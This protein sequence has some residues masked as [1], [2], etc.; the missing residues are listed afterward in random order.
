MRAYAAN[1]DFDWY[2]H[3]SRL[4]ALDEVNFWMPRPWG[5]E[6][7]VLSRGEP[8][9]FKL[10]APH[11]A[12]AGLGFFEHYSELPLSLAWDAFGE[13]NGLRSL[14]ELR[15]RIA[16]IRK[17]PLAP[18]VDDPIG[19][20]L[21]VEPVFWP[22]EFWIPQPVSWKRT[23]V[24]G[25]SYDLAVGV[26]RE[27]WARIVEC[28]QALPPAPGPHGSR[29][30][31][32]GSGTGDPIPG[33]YGDPLSQPRRMGQGI[34]RTV[35]TDIY[36]RECAVT[37]ERALPT[38]EAAHIKPFRIVAQ[39]RIQNGI[40]LRSDVHKLFDKGYLTVTEDH[41][42]EVSHRLRDDF[43]DGVNYEK[44]HGGRVHVPESIQL[45]P[46]PEALRWHNQNVFRG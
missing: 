42:V 9:L 37:R 18:W 15:E 6:F 24:R 34:F 20:I 33:G 25:K 26:G 14:H 1:T 16:K 35:I 10:K 19:C 40:L 8:L 45:Q 17:Q 31:V 27:L 21:L 46:D 43:N 29:Q 3:L 38:L 44:M 4:P 23:I 39:H 5:G 2:Q 12:I 13:K 30:I 7:G 41:H 36:G 28:L 32:S 22:E 11:N